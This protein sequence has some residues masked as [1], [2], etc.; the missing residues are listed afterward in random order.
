MSLL[1][2]A[3][4]GLL[5]TA[6]SAELAGIPTL[7]QAQADRLA[8]EARGFERFVLV[9][10]RECGV[11]TKAL[12]L[13]FRARLRLVIARAARQAP[14]EFIAAAKAAPAM[15]QDDIAQ[16]FGS[17]EEGPDA[18]ADFLRAQAS[19]AGI[20]DD[21][22]YALDPIPEAVQKRWDSGQTVTRGA[23]F[24]GTLGSALG[25]E[26]QSLPVDGTEAPESSVVDFRDVPTGSS[27]RKSVSLKDLKPLKA[28]GR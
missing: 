22:P 27:P 15:T 9:K 4:L 21:V 19:L 18:L 13:E 28:P 6:S 7:S 12:P 20:A 2:A 3:L 26:A 23:G 1:L 16:L 11:D 5:A 10:M 17:I 24:S 25:V 8:V 14:A